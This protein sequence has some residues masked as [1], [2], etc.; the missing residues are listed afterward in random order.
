MRLE[1]ED[2]VRRAVR[3][4]LA[5]SGKIWARIK[6][7]NEKRVYGVLSDV[8]LSISDF[9]VESPMFKMIVS[10]RSPFRV[11]AEGGPLDP[12]VYDSVV[13]GFFILIKSLPAGLYRIRFGGKGRGQYYTDAIYDLMVQRKQQAPSLLNDDIS[14][15]VQN[16]KKNYGI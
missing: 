12:G 4:D 13:G 7:K 6:E 15:T 5:H 2:S 11:H 16:P 3:V 10:E 8:N 9:H 14:A 1:N